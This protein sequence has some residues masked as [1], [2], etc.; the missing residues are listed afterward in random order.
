MKT[1][2]LM[3]GALALSLLGTGCVATHKY[4]AKTIAPVEQRVSG[5]EGKNADQDKQ[6]AAQG[7]HLDELD[8][9][10]SRTREKL[11]DV[12][13]K[14]VKAGQD[15]MVADQKAGA[16][17]QSADGAK[18]SA[19]GAKQVADNAVK[20]LDQL[21]QTVQGM[22]KFHMLKS[23]SVLFPLNA[24]KLTPDAKDQL[25]SLSKD[26]TSQDRYLVEVQGFTDKTGDAIYNESLSQERA[27]AVAR[28]MT[29]EFDI[30]VRNIS[31]LGSGYARP[32]GDD[33]T[34]DGRKMNRRVEVRV[35]V[36]DV[37]STKT[38]ASAA[39]AG[40]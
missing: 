25:T 20:G 22:N 15:A 9:D 14:A 12:D 33:K 1:L 35:W 40:Q 2:G 18:Q 17:Q 36:P 5:T 24:A 29:N 37:Q 31:I 28:F 21:G 6:I 3:S 34:R 10:A 13:G 26:A 7:T 27:Q 19:D 32:V 16:A 30:P 38:T 11:T 4:V 8:K 23:E 39:I